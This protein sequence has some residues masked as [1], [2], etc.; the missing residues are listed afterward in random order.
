MATPRKR[1]EDKLKVGRPSS[2][3]PEIGKK[4][5]DLVATHS[6]GLKKLCAEHDDLPEQ[7]TINKWM[8]DFPEFLRQYEVAKQHQSQLMIEECEELAASVETYIDAQG[9]VRRDSASVAHRKLMIDQKRWHA[10]KL[11]PKKYGDKALT[12]MVNEKGEEILAEVK[13][14]QAGL[15]K[16]SKKAY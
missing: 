15:N 13:K 12:E 10:S 9:N 11:A 16:K 5:C 2:Y 1:P 6:Y 14:V 8:W 3:T 7:V 4:I